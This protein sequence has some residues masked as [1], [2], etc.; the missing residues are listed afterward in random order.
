MSKGRSIRE[1]KR[2]LWI[3]DAVAHTG[4]SRVTHSILDRLCKK[5]DVS[6]LGINYK[7]DPHEYPYRIYP[8]SMRGDIYGINRL[9]DLMRD[10]QP[11]VVCMLNDFWI[12]DQYM[13]VINNYRKTVQEYNI[14]MLEEGKE[15]LSIPKIC[16]YMPVDGLNVRQEYSKALNDLDSV[17]AY[18]EF[19]AD[20]FRKAGVKDTSITVIPHGIDTKI[21]NP[22]N[23]DIAR[24][25]LN[26]PQEWYIIGLVGRN[27]PRK[28]IDLAI[29]YFAEWAKDKPDNVRFYYH[30]ALKDVGIDIPQLMQYY[31]MDDR[32]I[33]TS[34][35]L[36]SSLGIP[37]ERLKYMYSTHDVH[38]STSAGEGLAEKAL[39]L[40]LVIEGNK[41]ISNQIGATL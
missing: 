13:P 26:I 33:I 25:A 39:P 34:T 32:L 1:K 37:Q 30:G 6:I 35:G 38:I 27:Q 20:Q 7:G 2:L 16:A 11:D 4:F 21:F 3:G 28:R 23:R 24:K 36:T 10:I 31:G 29:R 19:G 5:Y 40:P 41:I 14:R 9:Y 22:V 18:T 12:I 8:A 17:I 15:Q